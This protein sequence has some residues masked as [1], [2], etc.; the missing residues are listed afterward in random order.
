M[1]PKLDK[2]LTQADQEASADMKRATELF[3]QAANEAFLGQYTNSDRGIALL[4]LA[5]AEWKAGHQEQAH[6][7]IARLMV[8]CGSTG[9]LGI[10][11]TLQ[12]YASL[13]DCRN[14]L[15]RYCPADAKLDETLSLLTGIEKILLTNSA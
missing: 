6:S 13:E 11:Q 7:T 14:I 8:F 1:D 15:I 12:Q 3:R 9:E 2:M 10:F 5:L 4:L